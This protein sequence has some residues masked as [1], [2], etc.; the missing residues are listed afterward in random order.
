MLSLHVPFAVVCVH[1]DC[2]GQDV[3]ESVVTTLVGPQWELPGA[4]TRTDQILAP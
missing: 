2:A 4:A 1:G 3:N